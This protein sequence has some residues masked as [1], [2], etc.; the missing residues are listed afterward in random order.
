MGV[1]DRKFGQFPGQDIFLILHVLTVYV[2]VERIMALVTQSSAHELSK[3]P[4]ASLLH[5]LLLL[6]GLYFIPRELLF[7]TLA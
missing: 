2:G 1:A 7:G 3:V 5:D 4:L 6:G